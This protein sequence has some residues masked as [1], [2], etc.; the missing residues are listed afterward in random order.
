MSSL[1]LVGN[2]VLNGTEYTLV[3]DEVCDKQFVFNNMQNPGSRFQIPVDHSNA[4][5]VFYHVD[6]QVTKPCELKTN[7]RQS[8]P[9][10]RTTD[11][12][13]QNRIYTA[14]L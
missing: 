3:L 14:L 7:H 10:I 2:V 8:Y 6:I 12:N 4:P 9:D 11:K 1:S 13:D 5:D